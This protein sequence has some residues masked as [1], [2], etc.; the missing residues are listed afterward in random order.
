M[1]TATAYVV[2]TTNTEELG[3]YAF[4]KKLDNHSDL[5][6]QL[7]HTGVVNVHLCESKKEASK[8]AAFWNICF[9]EN[10]STKVA[11]F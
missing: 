3:N 6:G 10:G 8:L 2:I 9:K 4:A 1:K 5:I 11:A 7:K